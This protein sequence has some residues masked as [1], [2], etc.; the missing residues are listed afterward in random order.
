MTQFFSHYLGIAQLSAVWG[1]E[2]IVMA[3][4]NVADKVFLPC[5]RRDLL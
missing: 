1:R 4:C 5:A 2:F 3:F